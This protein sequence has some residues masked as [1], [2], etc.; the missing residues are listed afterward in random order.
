MMVREK[1]GLLRGLVMVASITAVTTIRMDK[2][3]PYMNTKLPSALTTPCVLTSTSSPLQGCDTTSV[4][5]RH[6]RQAIWHKDILIQA[7]HS[8]LP[9]HLGPKILHRSTLP[10]RVPLWANRI[11]CAFVQTCPFRLFSR[12]AGRR[13]NVKHATKQNQAL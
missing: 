11:L 6:W 1:I 13:Q 7:P 5:E 3:K 8:S 2:K 10:T 12:R 9:L 4:F